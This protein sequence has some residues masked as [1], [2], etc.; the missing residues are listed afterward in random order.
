M[1]T[2]FSLM[3]LFSVLC[4]SAAPV[5]VRDIQLD[6]QYST[7]NGY[8]I[9]GS[10]PYG[11]LLR[12]SSNFGNDMA[13]FLYDASTNISIVQLPA[14]FGLLTKV[15]S[16]Y[17]FGLSGNRLVIIGSKASGFASDPIVH[18]CYYYTLSGGS[19]LYTTATL[20]T[21]FTFGL[22][23]LSGFPA[24]RELANGGIALG[25]A[26][27][28]I[29]NNV[30]ILYQFPNVSITNYGAV[31]FY[32]ASGAPFPLLGV[33]EQLGDSSV[34]FFLNKDAMNGT[35]VATQFSVTPQGM[36]FVHSFS[37]IDNNA[38]WGLLGGYPEYHYCE[39]I[40]DNWSNR[41]LEAYCNTGY[42]DDGPEA[43]QDRVTGVTVAGFTATNF[44]FLEG[45]SA[46]TNSSNYAVNR[47]SQQG[48]SQ[49][50]NVVTV[51]S[52]QA[53]PDGSQRTNGW[54][55]YWQK[56]TNGL[57][58]GTPEVLQTVVLG[59][60]NYHPHRLDYFIQKFSDNTY[61]FISYEPIS[62]PSTNRPN[63]PLNLHIVSL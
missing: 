31:R 60:I 47:E 16:H 32:G 46:T 27:H 4:M 28:E 35:N 24:V 29:L 6:P 26:E 51:T 18:W 1:K 9:H 39:A 40:S 58:K 44:Y 41:I 38:G 54:P 17:D 25:M 33:A 15:G 20:V 57:P 50:G 21:N 22:T 56:M 53:F 34:W 61:H 48:I 11:F 3:L 30:Y 13:L 45:F 55:L 42:I 19:P 59:Y 5:P 63:P 23:N 49:N 37:T 8:H 2:A 14:Q 43:I 52:M 36:S 12:K 10:G 7:H 62:S